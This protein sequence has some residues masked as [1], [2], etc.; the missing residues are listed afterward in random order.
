[1]MIL[2]PFFT[3]NLSAAYFGITI[4]L[5]FILVDLV[6]FLS[7]ILIRLVVDASSN[8]KHSKYVFSLLLL[9]EAST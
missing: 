3:F 6:P 7:G 4:P 5:S 9:D 8:A 2:S 1:M